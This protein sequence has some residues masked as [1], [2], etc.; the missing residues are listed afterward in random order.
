[1]QFR[2]LNLFI[3]HA[4]LQKKKKKIYETVSNTVADKNP[5]SFTSRSHTVFLIQGYA[6]AFK[7]EVNSRLLHIML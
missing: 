6:L 2:L 3:T 1:M 7:K 5:C 4:K